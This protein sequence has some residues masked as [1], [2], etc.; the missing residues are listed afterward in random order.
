[1]GG[2]RGER[3]GESQTESFLLNDVSCF[4]RSYRLSLKE[5]LQCVY[6]PAVCFHH[7]RAQDL[8]TIIT[9]W[10][11]VGDTYFYSHCQHHHGVWSK[12][13]R[14]RQTACGPAGQLLPQ[15]W[16]TV[17]VHVL[18]HQKGEI[19]N[20]SVKPTL[21]VAYLTDLKCVPNVWFVVP[22]EPRTKGACAYL[23]VRVCVLAIADVANALNGLSP[24]L[25]KV[26]GFS[27][28]ARCLAW[29]SSFS[30]GGC[31]HVTTFNWV[32]LGRVFCGTSRKASE[33]QGRTLWP[34]SSPC[35]LES[36]Y[37][38]SAPVSLLGL[39][40]DLEDSPEGW[41]V[42]REERRHLSWWRFCWVNH[43]SPDLPPL[44]FLVGENTFVCLGHYF[45]HLCHK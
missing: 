5:V 21:T 16:D 11:G 34:F 8:N 40:G 4:F 19:E 14:L 3:K 20:V 6:S 22:W 39:Q 38:A 42:E 31:G 41:D 44:V 15:G 33:K 36:W 25:L 35:R 24:S 18:P 2:G 7:P 29:R 17:K 12:F 43:T 37:E 13:T 27:W 30:W 10:E 26:A 28:A 45:W 23:W 1:M 9:M 32:D